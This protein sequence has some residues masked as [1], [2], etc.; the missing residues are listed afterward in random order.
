[1]HRVEARTCWESDVHSPNYLAQNGQPGCDGYLREFDYDFG[2]TTQLLM[3]LGLRGSR[4]MEVYG[5][6]DPPIVEIEGF[7][8]PIKFYYSEG[9]G[10]TTKEVMFADILQELVSFHSEEER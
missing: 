9:D 8:F 3:R 4:N 2:M 7:R 6:P 5:T 1:M 10:L